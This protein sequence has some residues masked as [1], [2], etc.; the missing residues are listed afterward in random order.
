MALEAISWRDQH[1]GERLATLLVI[2]CAAG[3]VALTRS[4][5]TRVLLRVLGMLGA[6]GLVAF[7]DLTLVNIPQHMTIAFFLGV[8]A[9]GLALI[10]V[11]WAH[12]RL[13]VAGLHGGL[14]A[15]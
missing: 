7:V 13:W 4:V 6:C 11:G 15:V 2:V 10:I 8:H 3:F 1:Y 5:A 14:V 9:C 12:R